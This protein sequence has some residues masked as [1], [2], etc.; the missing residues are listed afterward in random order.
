MRK[1]EGKLC[2]HS[3]NFT[4]ARLEPLWQK[5]SRMHLLLRGAFYEIKQRMKQKLIQT[6]KMPVILLMR[7]K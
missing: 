4:T 1:I 7:L 5:D 2:C 3:R 6:N